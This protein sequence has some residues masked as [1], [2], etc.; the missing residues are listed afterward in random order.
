MKS[1][2]S[3]TTA[4][5]AIFVSTSSAVNSSEILP[6]PIALKKQMVDIGTWK[7]A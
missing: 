4:V 5:L 1:F 3:I 7:P 6:L 2:F